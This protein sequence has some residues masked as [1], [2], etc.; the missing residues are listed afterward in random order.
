MTFTYSVRFVDWVV[1]AFLHETTIDILVVHS[2]P[3][4]SL[5]A[6]L[7]T[8]SDKKLGVDLLLTNSLK[9]VSGQPQKY[10]LGG[11]SLDCTRNHISHIY[12]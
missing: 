3:L 12:E 5:L 2:P 11:V 7:F 6:L 8:I 4:I 1:N 9:V 10:L